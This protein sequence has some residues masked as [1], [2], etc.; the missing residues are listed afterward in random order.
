MGSLAADDTTEDD[1]G[2]VTVIKCHLMGSV[3]QFEGTGN[4]LH[5]NVLR[6]GTVFLKCRDTAFEQRAR[7]LWIPLGHDDAE[8]HVRR[9]GDRC[10]IVV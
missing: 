7:N 3:D 5:V 1:H 4:G 8:D 2:I 6:Q 10:D 9:V